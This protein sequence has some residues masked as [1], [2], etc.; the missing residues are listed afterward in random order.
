VRVRNEYI[1]GKFEAI[2]ARIHRPSANVTE[3]WLPLPLRGRKWLMAGQLY[4]HIA[5]KQYQ[6]LFI[7]RISFFFRVRVSL[8]MVC[9]IILGE[10]T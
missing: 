10:N 9:S 2:L 8:D 5:S 4:S 1:R 7:I 6:Y 3:V